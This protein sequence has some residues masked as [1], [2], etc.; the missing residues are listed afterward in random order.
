MVPADDPNDAPEPPTLEG[1]VVSGDTV[2]VRV[3][4][5]GVDRNGDPV[6][7][8]GITSAPRL[9]RIVRP[10][11]ATSSS[12]R[13]TRARSART[14]S[15]TPSSTPRAPSRPARSGWPS[16]S[17]AAAAAAGGRGPAHRRAGTHGDVRPAG[18]RLHR[19]R[20]LGRGRDPRRS[21]RCPPRPRHQ[22]GDGAG[23][24]LRG[25]PADRARLPGHQRHRRVPLDDDA[26][27][28]GR[29]RQPA[30]RLRRLRP[31]RRQRERRRRRPRGRLRPGRRRRGPRG[32]RRLR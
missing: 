29:L 9:G 21:G 23:A 24:R 2:K 4:G 15:P 14:S 12:T 17:R 1:R 19:R 27:H 7:V 25:R 18:Q 13:P 3:P 20:R 5:V 11:A 16:S 22:P 31:G 30:D 32:R 28:R 10:S 6:T 26:D 8:T